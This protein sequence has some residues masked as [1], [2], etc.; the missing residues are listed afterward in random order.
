M[1]CVGIRHFVSRDVS[2]H[3]KYVSFLT[4]LGIL[5]NS[6]PRRVA[7]PRRRRSHR[8]RRQRRGRAPAAP[9]TAEAYFQRPPARSRRTP[10]RGYSGPNLATPSRW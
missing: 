7:S 4:Y 6:K 9:R 8:D 5:M 2:V 1:A 3:A 10:W